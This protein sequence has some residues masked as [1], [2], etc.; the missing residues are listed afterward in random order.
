M[1]EENYNCWESRFEGGGMVLKNDLNIRCWCRELCFHHF[2]GNESDST[3]PY[4]WWLQSILHAK[5]T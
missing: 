5:P 2:L 3:I 1:I 4:F